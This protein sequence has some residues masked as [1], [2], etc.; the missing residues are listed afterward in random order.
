MSFF[1]VN[2]PK[3]KV[4][5]G[6]MLEVNNLNDILIDINRTPYGEPDFIAEDD[7]RVIIHEEDDEDDRDKY[8]F[9]DVD[10]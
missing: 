9:D 1:F 6:Y 7:M 2:V 3:T 10:N 4:L 8:E 5:G